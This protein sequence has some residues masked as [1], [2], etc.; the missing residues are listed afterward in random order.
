LIKIGIIYH[1]CSTSVGGKDL[2]NDTQIRVI[3]SVDP[4][5]CMKMLKKLSEKLGAKFP[6]TICSYST[7]IIIIACLDAFSEFFELEAKR[8]EKEKYQRRKK[9]Q[10]NQ[11]A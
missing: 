2:S 9:K 6:A 8:K 1:L 4:E 5:I 11:K 3:G 7:V 10:K